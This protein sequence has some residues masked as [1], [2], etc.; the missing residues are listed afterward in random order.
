MTIAVDMGRKAAKQTKK[1]TME[2][3][4]KN[5]Q[6]AI[7]HILQLK[8]IKWFTRCARSHLIPL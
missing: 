4:E 2:F 6:K 1:Q 3:E 7:H 8:K 5:Y